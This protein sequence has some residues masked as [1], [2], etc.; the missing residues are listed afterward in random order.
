MKTRDHDG[1]LESLAAEWR[2][3]S[4]RSERRHRDAARRLIDGGS[5][6][7]RNLRP[8]P[9]SIVR[10]QGAWLD[11]EDGHRILDFWQGHLA[12]ILGD[13]PGVVTSA[14]AR[15]FWD[16][17][18]LQSGCVEPIEA[19][20]AELICRRTGAERI[21]FTT[22]GT[23]ANSYA[24]MLSMAWT[25]RDHAMKVGGGWHGAHLFG[26]KGVRHEGGFDHPDSQGLPSEAVGRVIVTRFND[27]Q[28]LEDDFRRH[29]DRL[30]CFTLEPM[31]GAGGVIPVT[32]DYLQSA[33]RLAD[34]H[35]VV[36]ILDE[37]ITGFRFRAGDAGGVLGVRGDL[38]VLG[39]IIGGG[40]PVAA[41][42]GRQEILELAGRP[43]TRVA[44]SGG[45]YSAHPA[46]MLAAKAMLTHLVEHEK[47]L[48]PRLARLGAA[49]RTAIAEGFG[50][51]GLR[52]R[53]TGAADHFGGSSLAFAHFPYHDDTV[54]DSPDVA[55]DPALCDVRLAR[56]VL[57]V[58]LLLEDVLLVRAH[59]A[60]SAA[61]RNEDIKAMAEA[62]RRTAAR[63]K[64]FL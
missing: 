46:C 10:A 15:A 38:T 50:S 57:E 26:L 28:R 13:N 51:E 20:V 32:R 14:L 24:V 7:N 40:M 59:G 63:L 11:D 18:G 8:F 21:R 42:A 9:P 6:G 35:G 12:N 54:I 16:G 55:L 23:L 62:C 64:P 22:S 25:G 44:F 31:V 33:R 52:V 61:H 17:S 43:S 34:R 4:P 49:L 56:D 60:A 3:R 27:T 45:T 1:L 19:E 29:G 30:A 39:K 41:V 5:H 58:A 48:Y 53:C 2:R 47:E 36:L 37:V